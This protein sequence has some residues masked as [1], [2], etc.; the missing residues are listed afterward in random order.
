MFK[1]CR[2]GWLLSGDLRCLALAPKIFFSSL[3][4]RTGLL[5]RPGTKREEQ[6]EARTII[7]R[8]PKT[9]VT[10]EERKKLH[11]KYPSSSVWASVSRHRENYDH[12]LSGRSTTGKILQREKTCFSFV[13]RNLETGIFFIPRSVSFHSSPNELIRLCS[14]VTHF[15]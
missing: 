1:R 5:L 10:A 13:F 8:R 6:R 7:S 15:G 9:Y 4:F 12:R 2:V 3:C 14:F 11:C